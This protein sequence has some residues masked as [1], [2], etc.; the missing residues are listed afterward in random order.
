M[1]ELGIPMDL[2][3]WWAAM[4]PAGTPKPVVDKINKWFVQ[5]VVVGGDQE[6]PQQASAAIR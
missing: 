6:V 1:T 2:I 5:M 4:V 3:G